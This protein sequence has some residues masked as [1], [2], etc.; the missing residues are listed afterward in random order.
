M[1][2]I[3]KLIQRIKNNP[4]NVRFSELERVVLQAGFRLE[5]V[6]GSHHVYVKGNTVLTIVKPHGRRKLCHP[7]DVR[8]V[9][10]FLEEEDK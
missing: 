5:R 3:E 6:G 10:N 7:Q 9:L 8:D 4:K 2:Q 1:T